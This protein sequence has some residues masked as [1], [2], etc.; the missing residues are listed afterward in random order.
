MCESSRTVSCLTGLLCLLSL[1]SILV[2]LSSALSS[3]HSLCEYTG[4]CLVDLVFSCVIATSTWWSLVTSLGALGEVGRSWAYCLRWES[5]CTCI[6]MN[7]F[8][9]A[10]L[11]SSLLEYSKFRDSLL[12][13][14]I[15]WSLNFLAT[16][17]A[18][19]IF[20]LG[21]SLSG[22]LLIFILS[23][24]GR[25]SSSLIFFISCLICSNS[26]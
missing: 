14:W 22:Y 18:T 1:S 5:Y 10:A 2:R 20:F 23:G 16:G 17:C 6:D 9:I 19:T 4:V 13:S 26:Y 12:V 25:S 8:P 3:Y 15:A 21:F 24:G 11:S 7:P